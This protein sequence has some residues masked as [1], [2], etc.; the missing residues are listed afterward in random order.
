MLHNDGVGRNTYESDD[1]ESLYD[2]EKHKG[3]GTVSYM[4][5]NLGGGTIWL[6]CIG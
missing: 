6:R 5:M 1:N 2:Y 4:C 3:R